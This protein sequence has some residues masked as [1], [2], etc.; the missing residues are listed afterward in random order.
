MTTALGL[1]AGLNGIDLLTVLI[2][3]SAFAT[4]MIGASEPPR[5]WRC[6]CCG[7]RFAKRADLEAHETVMS[8]TP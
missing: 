4:I 8:G 5:P 2:V 3:L 1:L 7:H 6:D